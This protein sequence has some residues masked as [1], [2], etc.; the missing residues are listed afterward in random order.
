M[1]RFSKKQIGLYSAAAIFVAV[2][3]MLIVLS[4]LNGQVS[5]AR[6]L[7]ED[8][9]WNDASQILRHYLKFQPRD[10]E[11]RILLSRCI[12][13]D[14]LS[15]IQKVAN[16][17]LECLAAIPKSSPES[18]TARVVE[19]R[20]YL[21][22]L[23]RPHAAEKCF[24]AAIELD[25]H[26]VEAHALLWKLYDLT[27]RWHLSEE[28]FWQVYDHSQPRDRDKLLR[29]WYLSEFHPAS[30]ISDLDRQL[31]I[32]HDDEQPNVEV[33]RRRYEMFIAAEPDSPIG[34]TCL[35]RWFH[36][37]GLSARGLEAIEQ[38]EQ[39]AGGREDPF[40]IATHVAMSFERGDFDE[41]REHFRRWPRDDTG[42]EYWKTKGLI[43]DQILRQNAESRDAYERALSSAA[44]QSDW[45]TRHR[46]AQVLMRMDLKD[47]AALVRHRSK[48]LEH[49]MEPTVHQPLRDALA[50]P[51]SRDTRRLI[52]NFYEGIG[53]PRESRAWSELATER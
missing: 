49:Q 2:C 13:S 6:E 4:W 18:A 37:Q 10:A 42:Y 3:C 51:E 48:E 26:R 46:L 9:R 28:H 31:G 39:L 20:I 23:L 15:S 25:P 36:Q 24:R 29:D 52:A 53:R 22:L 12:L 43:C 5:T 41:A 35:A 30:A 21:L 32:L 45:L 14:N 27:R 7:A 47:E 34:Y 50:H 38:A 16:D 17:A 40:T 8:Q 1:N 11:A 33:E 44:G 19:G